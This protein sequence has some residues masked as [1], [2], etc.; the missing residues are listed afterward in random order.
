MNSKSE[1][2]G[3]QSKYVITVVDKAAGNF[4]FT[5]KKLYFLKLAEELG[6]NNVNLGNETY[7]HVNQTESEIVERTKR[8][9]LVPD[10]KEERLALLYQTPKFHKN[11]P[12]MRYIAGNINTVTTRLD[13]IVALILKMCKTHF[14]NYCRKSQDFSG[15][16]YDFDVQ[17]SMEVKDMFNK[18]HGGA[19]SISI[20]DF[21]TLYTLFEHDHLL[22]NIK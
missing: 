13:N 2:D 17:T 3:L 21:S 16:R 5:C 10:K 9:N 12:K 19:L 22:G 1:L 18:A 14:K 11:P 4:A 15:I 7:L 6:M 8:F 20:N